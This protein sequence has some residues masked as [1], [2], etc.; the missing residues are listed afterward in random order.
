MSRRPTDNIRLLGGLLISGALLALLL[1]GVA[2]PEFR[3]TLGGVRG[4][5]LLAAF[6]FLVADYAARLVRWHWML[7]ELGARVPVSACARPFLVGFA[8]NNVLPLRAGDVARVVAFRDTLGLPVARIAGTLV[9]ERLLDLFVLLGILVCALYASRTPMLVQPPMRGLLLAA[10]GA[11]L[12][13]AG[14]FLAMGAFVRRGLPATSHTL[15]G[16]IGGWFHRLAQSLAVLG[17]P[18]RL[19]PLTAISVLCWAL[20]GGVFLSVARALDAPLQGVWLALAAGT[21]GTLVPSAPGHVG[22]FDFFAA[23]GLRATGTDPSVAAA[24]AL[25]VHGVLWFPLTVVG[26]ALLPNLR[27]RRRVG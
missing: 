3:A 12:L 2:W 26:L 13:G 4:A 19:A 8:L 17:R 1:R 7:R 20:E 11:A 14:A 22:T 5:P 16:R 10:G 23:A 24:F 25:L 21:L 9:V 27:R 6:A 15:L 18:A